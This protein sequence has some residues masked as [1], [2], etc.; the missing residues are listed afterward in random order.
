M[1]TPAFSS[2]TR[3][4]LS[5][6]SHDGPELNLLLFE[7]LEGVEAPEAVGEGALDLVENLLNFSTSLETAILASSSL[8]PNWQRG[9]TSYA[10][11][12]L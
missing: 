4:N 6:R 3:Q 11:H 8:S 10:A 1:Q 2:S 9:E 5:R 12:A 7:R